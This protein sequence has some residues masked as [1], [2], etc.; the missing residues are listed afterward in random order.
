[1]TLGAIALDTNAAIAL[2]NGDLSVVRETER[3][4][5][6][7]LP[8]TVVGELRFGAYRSA[9]RSHNLV[10]I[11]ALE[12][13]C[14]VLE[15]NSGIADTYGRLRA[16]LFGKGAPIPENDIWI[17][18]TVLAV[19]AALLTGDAHFRCVPGLRLVWARV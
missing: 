19:D 17:A 1:V 14:T 16:D 3:H 10:K 18:A 2:L 6:V 7:Y 11:D 8:A 5:T 9:R 13:R 4:A 12:M 15:V